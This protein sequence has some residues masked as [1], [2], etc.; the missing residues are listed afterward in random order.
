MK[1]LVIAD[2][3]N[4][5]PHA[6][7]WLTTQSYGKVIFLGDFFD[8]FG[9]DVADARRTAAWLRR[10]IE[11]TRD[12]F[13]LGNHDASYM[14]PDNPHLFCP[15]FSLEKSE[16]IAQILLPE[17][18]KRFQMMSLEQGWLLSHAGFRPEWLQGGGLGRLAGLCDS[19]LQRAENGLGDP[20]LGAGRDR[21][22]PQ[23]IGGPL[24]LDWQS[25]V[26]I[27]GINQVVG[28]TPGNQVRE[29]TTPQSQNF[30]L[31]VFNGMASA[32]IE[33][34]AIRVLDWRGSS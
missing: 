25:L 5:I 19:A 1:T 21:G 24:W 4:H 20:L 7:H 33:D 30:C 6:E 17:H 3:H 15:G 11:G 8:D 23:Q 26:P 13:L 2:L 18:W 27:P 28:H 10:R 14:F 34:G 32:I 31:D 22:G 9:D 16:G 29:K 12:V